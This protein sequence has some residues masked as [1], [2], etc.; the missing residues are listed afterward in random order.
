MNGYTSPNIFGSRPWEVV[1]VQQAI[2]DV[3]GTVYAEIGSTYGGSYWAFGSCLPVGSLLLSVDRPLVDTEGSV[4]EAVAYMRARH[5]DPRMVQG[6]SHAA[7]TLEQ[8]VA[9]LGGRPIDVLFIDGDHGE[10]G[11]QQD[12]DMYASLVR[13]GGLVI[14]HDC[15][16]VD[17]QPSFPDVLRGPREAFRK[18]AVGRLS[19]LIQQWV[20][21]GLVWK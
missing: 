2:R 14:F 7:T 4:A 21:Y 17:Q 13:D 1:Q 19:L 8:A 12:V 9:V 16:M 11:V 5:Y 20:G 3:G 6:D 18:F 15:G 10:A